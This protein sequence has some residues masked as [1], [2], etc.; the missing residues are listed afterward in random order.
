MRRVINLARRILH[1]YRASLEH[2]R[3]PIEGHRQAKSTDVLTGSSPPLSSGDD[4]HIGKAVPR[5]LLDMLTDEPPAAWRSLSFKAL[6]RSSLPRPAPRPAR[7][8]GD[9]LVPTWSANSLISTCDGCF[10]RTPAWAPDII[11]FIMAHQRSRPPFPGLIFWM[12]TR[13]RSLPCPAPSGVGHDHI[14]NVQISTGRAF[15]RGDLDVHC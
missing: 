7:T 5:E 2:L 4:R 6:R 12:S 3:S 1:F 11:Q 15:V 9:Q 10:S 13:C 8:A 14:G